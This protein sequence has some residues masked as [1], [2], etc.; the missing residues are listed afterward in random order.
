VDR[1]NVGVYGKHIE[2]LRDVVPPEKLRLFN[3]K[4]GWEPLCEML[5]VDVPEVPFPRIN[6][7]EAIDR[8]A[9]YHIRRGLLR[10]GAVVAVVGAVVWGWRL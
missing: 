8:T 7:S 4:D 9:Q 1:P 5:G 10:W 2:R 6:D 3:V